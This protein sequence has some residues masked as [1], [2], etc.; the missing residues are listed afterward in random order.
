MSPL[1]NDK[2]LAKAAWAK[3]VSL[4]LVDEDSSAGEKKQPERV[5][6]MLRPRLHSYA[7]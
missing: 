1:W 7:L 6:R 5:R 4:G 2:A 3:A